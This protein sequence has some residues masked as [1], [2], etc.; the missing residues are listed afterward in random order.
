MYATL[1]EKRIATLAA[2]VIYEALNTYHARY[3]GITQRAKLRFKN[4]D[5]QSMQRDA[6]ERL[7]LYKDVVDHIERRIKYLLAG[8]AQN[9]QVWEHIKATYSGMIAGNDDRELAETF[10]NSITRRIF[11][12]VGV[13]IKIEF[14]NTYFDS[15]P[16]QFSAPVFHTYAGQES[17]A[18]LIEQILICYPLMVPFQNAAHDAAQVAA[19][20]DRHLQDLETTGTIDRIE[21]VRNVFY[22]GMGAYLIG[23]IYAE[24]QLVPLAI[25][26]LHLPDG[27]V[28]DAV[29]LDEDDVSILFSFTRSYF[30]VVV[31]RPC[32]LINFLSSILPRKRIAELYISMGFTKHGKTEIYRELL[33]HLT[34]CYE[35]RFDISPGKP[36]MVMIVFNMPDYDLVFKL[37]RDRFEEPKNTT[38][39][40]VM[41]KYD[42]VFRHDRAGRL[43]DAQSFEHLKF[44]ACCFSEQLLA[45]LKQEAGSTVRIKNDHLIVDHAY[46]ERRV[47]PL[48]VFLARADDLAARK[49]VID[50]G[51]TIKDLAVSNIFPGDILLKNFGVTRHGRV[52]FYDYDELCPLTSCNIRKLPESAGYDDEMA[53]EPWFFVDKNDVFP[54]EF[55]N[56][57][58]LPEP[59]REVFLQHHADLLEVDFWLRA[60]QAIQAGNLPHIYPYARSCRIERK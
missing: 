27:I 33:D 12:T 36:G 30:H 43:V 9:K 5:W 40:E 7:N 22:R 39:R 11:A 42:L 52:V 57:L 51:N 16:N 48:D 60:Q 56:F 50:W 21:M 58:G 14:V 46:V 10:F 59:L 31:D 6:A 44:D 29:L 1:T 34:V 4:R 53:S 55:R 8:R 18:E 26:L 3:K 32:D 41:E 19:K 17:T 28:V 38:R 54:Q 47:T 2:N 25:A 45:E 24:S 37:I 15:P 23:R 49:I 13:D 35:D 20:I